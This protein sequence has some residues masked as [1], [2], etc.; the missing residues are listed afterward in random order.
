VTQ[1]TDE[2]DY[3]VGKKIMFSQFFATNLL[4]VKPTKF[5][6]AIADKPN[7]NVWR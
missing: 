2:S 7:D 6:I 4:F 1:E 3:G 5:F